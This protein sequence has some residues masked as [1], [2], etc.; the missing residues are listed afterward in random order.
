MPGRVDDFCDRL[1]GDR[2][3]GTGGERD[4]REKARGTLAQERGR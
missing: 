2:T 1:N 4:E 3:G